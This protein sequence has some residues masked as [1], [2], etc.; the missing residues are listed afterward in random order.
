MNETMIEETYETETEKADIT[1]ILELI[2]KAGVP[3]EIKSSFS[4]AIEIMGRK[5]ELNN[6]ANQIYELSEELNLMNRHYLTENELVSDP[7]INI[8]I[9]DII[10][11]YI[12]I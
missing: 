8:L 7:T 10:H 6:R 1:P 9:H 2:E 3:A 12:E 5:T 4:S 11:K